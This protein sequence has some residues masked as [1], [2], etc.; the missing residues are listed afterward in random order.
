[1]EFL[2]SPLDFKKFILPSP[3]S[4]SIFL[5]YHNCKLGYWNYMFTLNQQFWIMADREILLSSL[6]IAVNVVGIVT[7]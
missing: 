5:N 6:Y 1:M 4:P 7:F 3:S 2:P